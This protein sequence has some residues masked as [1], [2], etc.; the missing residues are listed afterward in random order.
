MVVTIRPVS[1]RGNLV[2]EVSRND[3]LVY[4]TETYLEPEEL[5]ER[6]GKAL[7]LTR[8]LRRAE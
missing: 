3:L 7:Q 5:E 2:L 6:L 4:W 1:P 8:S